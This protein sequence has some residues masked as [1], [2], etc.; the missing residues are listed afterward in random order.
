MDSRID[1]LQKSLMNIEPIVAGTNS[2][3]SSLKKEIDVCNHKITEVIYSNNH[4]REA[5][6]N[7][8]KEINSKCC[9]VATSNEEN[10]SIINRNQNLLIGAIVLIAINIIIN[11]F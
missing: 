4:N 11:L 9:K 5:I 10:K 7:A 6:L 2:Q 8:L 1:R 3:Y